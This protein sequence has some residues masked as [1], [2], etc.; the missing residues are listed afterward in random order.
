MEPQM[1]ADERWWK[2][3]MM[4]VRATFDAGETPHLRLSAFI[5]GS[6]ALTREQRP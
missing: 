5:C 3:R 1:N 2:P 6:N 4:N